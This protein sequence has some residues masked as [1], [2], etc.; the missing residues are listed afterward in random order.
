MTGVEGRD[1]MECKRQPHLFFSVFFSVLFC[2]IFSFFAVFFFTAFF[3][4]ALDLAGLR[5]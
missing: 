5:T 2:A 1:A 4:L 3:F